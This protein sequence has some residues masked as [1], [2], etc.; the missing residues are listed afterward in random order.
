MSSSVCTVCL[1]SQRQVQVFI[2]CEKLCVE[3]EGL[4]TLSNL[5][6]RVYVFVFW[7]ASGTQ[8]H[9]PPE[10]KINVLYLCWLL[11]V[12]VCVCAPHS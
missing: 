9:Y 3:V 1:I 8:P 10:L 2:V 4:L 11:L 12:C 6:N 5:N 7:T